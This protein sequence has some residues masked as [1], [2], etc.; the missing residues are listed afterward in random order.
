ML[1]SFALTNWTCFRDRQELSAEAVRGVDDS[2][3]FDTGVRRYPKLNRVTAVYGANG[4]GKSFLVRGLGFMQHLVS[5]S[6]T[7]SQAGEAIPFLPFL[8]DVE[9]R[10]QPSVFEVAFIAGGVAYEYGF[11]TDR[12][13]VHEEW[14]LAWPPPYGRR[15]LLLDRRYDPMTKTEE[16]KFGSSVKGAKDLWRSSTR[17]NAL[18]A[19]VA[20]QLNSDVF[21]PV[22]EWF[23]ALRIIT[24]VT[25]NPGYTATQMV[26]NVGFKDRLVT[27]LRDADIR[28]VDA[29]ASEREVSPDEAVRNMSVKDALPVLEKGEPIRTVGDIKL[30]HV[31]ENDDQPFFLDLYFES[32]GTQKLFSLAGPWLEVLDNNRVLVV[33]ELDNSLHPL[34]VAALVSRINA[35]RHNGDDNRAQL[36]ATMHDV[37]LL[38]DRLHRDQIWFTEKKRSNEASQI[39]PLSDYRRN[40]RESLAKDYLDGRFGGVPVIVEP[41]AGD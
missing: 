11:A 36:L 12:D 18:L 26:S 14:L 39:V 4:S 24:P 41:M 29:S 34:L 37:S 23:Q 8:F 10:T 38:R 19:S 21:R 30:A 33:D 6:A 27:L 16:W 2:Y 28:I 7:A 35:S 1:V 9:T 17:E 31:V 20:A 25:A 32:D 3:A 13:R 22:V 15:R 5:T 40:P